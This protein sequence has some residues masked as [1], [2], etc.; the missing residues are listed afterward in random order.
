M[1]ENVLS[2]KSFEELSRSI[3]EYLLRDTNAKITKTCY[4]K[5]G[6]YDIIAEY[7]DN[8]IKQC[9][10]FECKLRNKNLNLRDIAANIII[11]FNHGAV[12]LVAVTNHD[13][14][15][16]TGEELLKFC[17]HTI[18]NIKIIVG[19]EVKYLVKMCG[20]AFTNDLQSYF[21]IKKTRRKDNFQMLRINFDDEI[22]KQLSKRTTDYKK[23]GD[24]LIEEL[25]YKEVDG[26]SNSLLMGYLVAVSGY[27]GV[28][29][30]KII[31]A[32]LER[33]KKHIICID[34][35]LHYTKD[36]VILDLLAQIWGIPTIDIFSYFTKK[37][38]EAI[39]EVVGDKK[40]SK[41]TVEILTALLNENYADKHATARQNALL[42]NYIANLIILHEKNIGYVF[43]IKKLQFASKEIYDFLIYLTKYLSILS[44]G[45]VISYQE[46]EYEIQE[47]RNPLETLQHVEKYD[48]HHIKPLSKENALLYIQKKYPELPSHV[49]E[50]IVT[51]VGTRLYN[52][53]HLLKY[54]I[55]DLPILPSESKTILQKLRFIT[56]NNVSNQI[57]QILPQL[58]I[59]YSALFETCFIF[60]CR[61]SLEIYKH[62]GLSPQ[63]IDNLVNAG[64]FECDHNII[65]AKNEFV[66]NWIMSAYLDTTPSIQLRALEL[67]K[68]LELQPA[69]HNT[70]RISIY[71]ILGLNK[72]ALKL[73]DK[74]I[75]S[76]KREKQ[77]TMLKKELFIA[78]AI[79]DSLRNYIKKAEYLVSLLETMTIQK[80][81]VTT[82][83][84]KYI[85]LLDNCIKHKTV[86]EFYSFAL[87]FFKLKRA[88][89]L[90]Q[91][92]KES[93]ATIDTGKKYYNACLY[94]QLTDNSG[95]WLGKICSCY[96]LLVKETQGNIPALKIYEDALEIFP[97]SF[98]LR[99]EYLSHIACM[100]LYEKPL[101]AFENY[102]KILTLFK[103]EAP[104]SAALP[105]HEYGDLAMSQLIA[106]N[107]EYALEL[108]S[109]AIEICRSYGLIDEEGRCLNIRGCVEWRSNNLS[110]AESSFLEATSIMC[111]AEYLHYSWR[112]QINL[113][114]LSLITG[115]YEHIRITML[116][117]LYSDFRQL[118]AEKIRRL[119][120]CDSTLFRKSREYH[121]LL[122][123]GF[124]WN[125]LKDITI[126]H[127]KVCD[128]FELGMHR[129]M[130][131]KDLKSFISGDY[132]FMVSPYIQNG[133][134]YFVG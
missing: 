91:Y 39:T 26:I 48:E 61:I 94:R 10:F 67:L 31:Q 130:Y 64:I 120:M 63:V 33:T 19:E 85:S 29:K 57:A 1:E 35:T 129:V 62:L 116:K 27:L 3:V 123:F 77:Y 79:A 115:N 88:F 32:A 128:D 36:L 55:P 49:A 54:L 2:S 95:D 121:A 83:A 73:L 80:E 106:G 9:A 58:Q 56:P 133:Y 78:I 124:L 93:D 17:Q 86:P 102:Q 109:E 69:S 24:P 23:I 42:S 53:S 51:K 89:K 122:A 14:T 28:G 15:Q 71:R 16:Q 104:D 59:K 25:F 68:I 82:D 110:A 45:C 21:D 66:Y 134:I 43:Y 75:L 112:S 46:P 111:S 4:N 22:L 13:F 74:D 107:L 18:L 97:S 99:R 38:L 60:D 50:V 5:D 101:C 30:H 126:N 127:N 92:T 84:E 113:L 70:E 65:I 118:L 87:S 76:L 41:E 52:L 20:S 103:N 37:D 72:E 117:K 34:S 7:Y 96:A 131:M 12:A 11:A 8:S 100:Q 81:I 47:T 125:A 44:I 98:E 114:Q 40:T 90:G 105:F 119:A 6:G 108:V 132:K